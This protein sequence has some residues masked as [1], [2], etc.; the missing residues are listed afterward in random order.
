MDRAIKVFAPA[1]VANIA[2]GFDIMGL[3]LKG[4]GDTLV[5]S[6]NTTG[7]V[8]MGSITGADNLPTDPEKNVC[9]VAVNALLEELKSDQGF[10]IDLHKNVTPG[11]GLGSSA[12]SAAG[13]V[14]AVNELLDRPFTR[15]ALVKYAMAGEKIASEKAHADNV[16][17]SLMGGITIIR[18]YTPLDIFTIP[19]PKD[20]I[21]SVIFPSVEIKTADAK[22]ILKADV[23]LSS[24]ITQWGNVAGLT[25]GLI[26]SD[27]ELIGR[28]M[29]DVIVEPVRSILIPGYDDMKQAAMAS[30]A[31]GCNISGSGPSVFAISRGWEVA[32]K[33]GQAMGSVLAGYHIDYQKFVSEINAEGCTILT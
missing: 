1:T 29:E 21:V 24:A 2:C 6:T 26:T 22:R 10:T 8:T 25:A 33:V 18:S 30:G 23:P 31:L 28:S 27:Y 20:L 5:I 4:V 9:T 7:R 11:S 3:A 13:A 19:Y 16:G 14:F 15:K 12:S 32:E 17:P